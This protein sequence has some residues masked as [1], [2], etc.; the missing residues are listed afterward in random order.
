MYLAGEVYVIATVQVFSARKIGALPGGIERYV[1]VGGR[2]LCRS[3]ESAPL[4]LSPR[5]SFPGRPLSEHSVEYV[6]GLG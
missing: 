1:W 5:L 2:T 3:V 4:D 6:D